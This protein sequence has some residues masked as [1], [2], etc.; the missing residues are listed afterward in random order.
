MQS[1]SQLVWPSGKLLITFK[2]Q[3]SDQSINECLKVDF[4]K[5]GGHLL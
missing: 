4:K 5:L 1:C 3:E 2:V